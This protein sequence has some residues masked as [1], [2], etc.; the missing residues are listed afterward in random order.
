MSQNKNRTALL[1]RKLGMSQVWDE[2]GFFVP[3]TLVEVA[4]NVVTAV[5]TVESD[6]YC[7]VQLGYGQID[8]TKVTKP[9]AGHFAKAGVTPRRHLAEVRTENAA[10]YQPGQELT[11]ELFAEGSEVDVTG[12]TK[13]KG[14]AGTIKRWGFKSYRRTH[15]SHKNERRP[16]SVG[17]CAT[18]SRILKGKRMAGRMGHVT[19]TALNLTIVSSDVENGI[20]AIKGAVP[21]PKG[22]IVLVRSAVK[23]A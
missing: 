3:V 1:G 19:S 5:K 4:T 13:G 22:A 8:P 21:G 9:L 11:A 7:A 20:L 12:T 23:G 2:N 14:F 6:G 17:A 10:D 15:G 16:G 18:P